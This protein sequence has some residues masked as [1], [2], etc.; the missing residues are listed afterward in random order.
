MKG[1]NTE[2]KRWM[3]SSGTRP[4]L[5]L[6]LL[7]N[8][9]G[10][11]VV[12][13]SDGNE[14]GGVVPSELGLKVGMV[15]GRIVVVVVVLGIVVGLGVDVGREVEVVV[16][17]LVPSVVPVVAGTVVCGVSSLDDWTA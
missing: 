11:E 2:K 6:K 14:G 1:S 8:G 7:W 3:G 13:R 16:G 4:E 5:F 10:P 15:V 12:G 9:R 17:D